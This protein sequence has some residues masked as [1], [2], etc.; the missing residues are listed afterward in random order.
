MSKSRWS[1]MTE[2][3]RAQHTTREREARSR[4]RQTRTPEQDARLSAQRKKARVRRKSRPEAVIVDASYVRERRGW[5]I[6]W[7][8]V[9][10]ARAIKKNMP[11]DLDADYLMSIYP[12]KCPVFGVEFVR[13]KTREDNSPWSPTVDRIVPALGYVRGNVIIVCRRANNIKSDDTVDDIQR[14]ADFYRSLGKSTLSF[15]S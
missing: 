7:A 9:L 15:C 14:V 11:Y 13:K 5:F 1:S 6:R 12:D 3:Q 8:S 4:R 2:E 10:K